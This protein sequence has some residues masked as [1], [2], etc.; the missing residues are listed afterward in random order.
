METRERTIT[1]QKLSHCRQRAS[2]LANQHLQRGRAR[3]N[4][5]HLAVETGLPP[6]AAARRRGSVS[7][8]LLPSTSCVSASTDATLH[9]LR[10]RIWSP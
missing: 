3:S 9:R 2:V 6:R 1:V 7:A 4:A 5:A 10:R 8:A